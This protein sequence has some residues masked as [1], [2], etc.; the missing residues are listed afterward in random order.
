MAKGAPDAT[1]I[2]SKYQSLYK[3][4]VYFIYFTVPIFGLAGVGGGTVWAELT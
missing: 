4:N 3:N 2:F 1:K